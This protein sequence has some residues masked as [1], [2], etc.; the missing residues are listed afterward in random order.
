MHCRDGEKTLTLHPFF[1]I[2]FINVP[3]APIQKNEWE[4]PLVFIFIKRINVEPIGFT[5]K[6]PKNRKLLQLGEDYNVWDESEG[7]NDSDVVQ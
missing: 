4:M 3:G 2:D 1:F 6:L 7:I 5:A